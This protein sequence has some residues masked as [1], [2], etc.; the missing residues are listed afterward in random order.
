MPT[1]TYTSISFRDY[2]SGNYHLKRDPYHIASYLLTK[3]R[4]AA[5]VNCP[6]NTSEDNCAFLFV[7]VDDTIAARLQC[8]GTRFYARGKI[9]TAG[10]ASALEAAEPLRHLGVGAEPLLAF[11]MSEEYPVNI[12]AGLS[13]MAQ[14]LYKKLHYHI[15]AFP[16]IMQLRDVRCML[17]NKG[18]RG[19][20]LTFCSYVL[21]IPL[22]CFLSVS[23]RKGKK[24]LQKYQV[25]K[26]DR[27]PEWVDE[28]V[29][30][31]GHIY[32]EVHDHIWLQWNL[33][34]NF[35][36]LP[37]DI[38]S[39]YIVKKSGESI[40]FFMTKERFREH[41]GGV[42]QNVQ[43]G[44]IVEWGSRDESL[45]SEE[46]IYRMAVFTFSS[47]VDIIETATNNLQVVRA[48][49]RCGF[50]PHGYAHIA[51]KDKTKQYKDASDINLWRVRY[52]YADVILT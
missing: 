30:N 19:K 45:L 21:N 16:R 40:G 34:N 1:L 50:I 14:P 48:M 37:Q 25:E 4:I 39:F 24:L 6:F 28:I 31:D 10:T 2:L 36:G 29:L 15:L 26:V 42:L 46:D 7:N 11:T 22:R 23:G 18:I 32:M 13:E 12:V 38:Q 49:K 33:D 44:S 20:F 35:H 8:F 3:D 51:L 5:G 52:G 43:I 27:V 41:A 9:L 47:Q 17:E